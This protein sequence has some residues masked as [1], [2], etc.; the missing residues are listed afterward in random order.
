MEGTKQALQTAEAARQFML[1]GKARVTFKSQTTGT[2]VTFRI[3]ASKDRTTHFVSV[4]RGPQN[5][6]DYSY[7]GFI[8]RGI[9]YFGGLKSTISQGATSV[10][11]FEWAWRALAQDRMPQKLEVWHEGRCG[12]CGRALTV[13]ESIKSGFGPECAGRVDGQGSFFCE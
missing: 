1:A 7:F 6:S 10:K 9:F 5:E 3:R 13:P 4:L 2:H 12:R 8:R 11:A